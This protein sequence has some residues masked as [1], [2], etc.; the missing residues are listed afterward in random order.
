MPCSVPIPGT[1]ETLKTI[2]VEVVRKYKYRV[3]LELDDNHFPDEDIVLDMACEK[4]DIDTHV[5][6]W[7]ESADIVEADV[8]LWF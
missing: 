8:D 2:T 4:A 1:G 3:V 5:D 7:T 6:D